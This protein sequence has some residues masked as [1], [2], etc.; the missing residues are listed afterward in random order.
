M[1]ENQENYAAPPAGKRPMPIGL[2]GLYIYNGQYYVP[3]GNVNQ[4][5][6][7]RNPKV[8]LVVQFKPLADGLTA[9]VIDQSVDIKFVMDSFQPTIVNPQLIS[10]SR[11]VEFATD[12]PG[13]TSLWMVPI[14]LPQGAHVSNEI[15]LAPAP[16]DLSDHYAS[17]ILSDKVATIQNTQTQQ[18]RYT[19][20]ST[21]GQIPVS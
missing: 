2:M 7:Q 16:T 10:G 21:G 4:A 20:V 8:F 11:T 3:I 13:S 18:F 17:V 14:N 19:V 15:L 6:F 1:P 5:A 9:A 12:F